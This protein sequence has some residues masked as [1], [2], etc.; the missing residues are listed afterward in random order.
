MLCLL[1]CAIVAFACLAAYP[2]CNARQ[3]QLPQAYKGVL[4]VWHIDSFEGGTGSRA[5]F[6]RSAAREF[7]EE[8]GMYVLITVHT[9]E[10]AAHAAEKGMLPD[11]LSF[12]RY[13]D[14][15]ADSVKPLQ[16]YDFC[17]SSQGGKTYA[18]PWCRGNYFLFTAEGDFSDVSPQNTVLSDGGTLVN[19]A[20]FAQGLT[21]DYVEEE[22]V[23]AYVSF[24]NGKYKYMIGT[25]RDLF[26]FRTRGAQVQA[27]PLTSFC[28]LYQYM[29]IC[30][31]DPV[32]FSASEKFVACILSEKVQSRL[33]Q[34]GMLSVYYDVYDSS[35]PALQAA[36]EMLPLSGVSAFLSADVQTQLLN[37]ARAAR[38][39]DKNGAIFLQNIL[40]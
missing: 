27:R 18:V 30:T 26:R 37:A 23:R 33:S 12:G 6:L 28:D 13:F 24:L 36:Q 20:A 4:R 10:S 31:G 19:A 7:E 22:S 2:A 29:S 21:G 38:E 3:E 8:S 17:Y 32:L 5:A 11:V 16:G 25:Q 34:I 39:G 14:F 15:A 9:A 35:E 1:V 40:S